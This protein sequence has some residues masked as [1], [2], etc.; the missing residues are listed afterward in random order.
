MPRTDPFR[1]DSE[2]HRGEHVGRKSVRAGA[3]LM[4]AEAFD[5]AFRILS[6]VILARMLLPEHFGIIGMV[7]AITA[8]VERFKDLGLS[9][10][11]VQRETITPAQVSNLFWV[12]VAVGSALMLGVAALAPLLVRFYHEPRLFDITLALAAGFFFGGLAVQHQAL[13]RRQMRFG[14]LAVIQIS[15][16]LLSLAVAIAMALAD[17][18]YW[19]LVA[20]EVLRAVFIAAGTWIALPWRPMLP[21]KGTGVK[22]M[23]KFGGDVTAFNFL[24]FLSAN[25]DQ[26][27]VGRLFGATALGLYRQGVNLV[28][29]PITQL[30]YPIHSVAEAGLSRLQGHPEDYRRYVARTITTISAMT[31]PLAV[32]LAVFAE[33]IVLVVLGE[34]WRHAAPFF[35]L[36]AVAVFFRPAVSV[37]GAVLISSGLSRRYLHSGAIGATGLVI[38]VAIGAAWGA[39]GVAWG[40]VAY[41]YLLVPPMIAWIVRGT[42]IKFLDIVRAMARPLL[43]SLV[44]AALLLWSATLTAPLAPLLQLIV[45]AIV[46]PPVILGVWAALPGGAAELRIILGGAAAL[47]RRTPATSP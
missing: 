12:N 26:I 19:A 37:T 1:E 30:T 31:M 18:G 41:S 42:P 47:L 44:C 46:A 45:G 25:F 17:F 29:S 9:A 23:L 28:L 21:S 38:C 13:L 24:W 20:R 35:Q 36:F 33:P 4:L 16:S 6:V 5:F 3:A 11:T 40:H 34:K 39:T 43:A 7:T 27:L 14:A 15:A 8:I 10:A 22:S 2:G 32:F